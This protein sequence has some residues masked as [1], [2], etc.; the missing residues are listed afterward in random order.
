VEP[1]VVIGIGNRLRHDDGLGPAVVAL[2]RGRGLP[3]DVRLVECDGEPT[4]LIDMWAGH[5]LAVVV[6]AMRFETDPDLARPGRICRRSLRH[7]SLG[8]SWAGVRGATSSHGMGLATAI[9]L[10]AALDLLPPSILLYAVEI[11]D[12]SPGQGLTPAVAAAA[13]Q[14]ADEIT[15]LLDRR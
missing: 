9:S 14:V 10:A 11:A 8:Q 13:D 3:D 15:A 5:S 2:L 1:A 7:P 4:R 12:S 6:D